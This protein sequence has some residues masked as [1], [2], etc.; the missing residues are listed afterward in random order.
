M[1][2]NLDFKRNVSLGRRNNQNLVQIPLGNLRQQLSY[3]SLR[4]NL[5][6]I[7][8]EESYTSKSSFLDRDLLPVYKPEQPFTGKFSG[9]RIKRG[10]YRSADGKLLN[11]DVNGSANIMRKSKQK[12]NYE[13]LCIGLLASP[14]RIRLS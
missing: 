9:K 14:K 11:A 8:Q 10:L 1:G 13:Q 4:Y 2:Y 7:E 5:T 6:Y 3:L 12:F